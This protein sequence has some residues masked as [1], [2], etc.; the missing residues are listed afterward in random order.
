M[1]ITGLIKIQSLLFRHN[2]QFIKKIH[3]FVLL[4]IQITHRVSLRVSSLYLYDIETGEKN[5]FRHTFSISEWYSL[6]Y[7]NV[8]PLLNKLHRYFLLA[9]IFIFDFLIFAALVITY[10]VEG[11]KMIL[12][13]GKWILSTS[14]DTSLFCSDWWTDIM[15][16]D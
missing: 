15:L 16:Q 9:H 12:K 14:T 1:Y 6:N 10:F 2:C 3:L 11:C 5:I 8:I 7:T 13:R 4:I